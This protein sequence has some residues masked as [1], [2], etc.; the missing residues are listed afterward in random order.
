MFL[1]S[2]T[3]VY[4]AENLVNNFVHYLF[5]MRYVPLDTFLRWRYYSVMADLRVPDIDDNLMAR[6][7]AGAA[8]A[9]TTLKAF[10]VI[11]LTQGL[12]QRDGRQRQ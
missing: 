9:Q 6:L 10:V 8:L 7:K 12:K 1:L 11:L 3:T 2:S 5:T 4:A